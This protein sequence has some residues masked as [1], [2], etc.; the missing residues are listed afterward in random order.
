MGGSRIQRRR[1]LEIGQRF[2]QQPCIDPGGAA[3]VV[4]GR[5]VW[6]EPDRRVVVG[7]AAIEVAFAAVDSGPVMEGEEI[8][9]VEDYGLVI[10][11]KRMIDVAAQLVCDAATV[12]RL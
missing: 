12:E 8:G 7:E 2:R 3:V 11:G 9:R 1:P 4:K 10:I 5:L 6:M